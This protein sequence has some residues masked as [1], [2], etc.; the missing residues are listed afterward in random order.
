[1][2][3]G[4]IKPGKDNFGTRVTDGY[5]LLCGCLESNPGSVR[6]SSNLNH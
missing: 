5:E 3:L 1:M 6:A 2:F 4:P